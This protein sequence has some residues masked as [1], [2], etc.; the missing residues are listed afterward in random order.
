MTY[1]VQLVCNVPVI[2]SRWQR[3]ANCKKTI[4][5]A[6]T[7]FIVMFKITVTTPV[8][9]LL[10]VSGADTYGMVTINFYYYHNNYQWLIFNQLISTDSRQHDKTRRVHVVAISRNI[11]SITWTVDYCTLSRAIYKAIL[12]IFTKSVHFR[13]VLKVKN[14]FW[15]VVCGLNI[16]LQLLPT[17]YE[18]RRKVMFEK[19]YTVF[20]KFEN[21]I[22]NGYSKPI[23]KMSM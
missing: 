21:L 1:T 3:A 19:H 10:V 15:I 23:S 18:V 11:I 6:S 12:T 2:C 9:I 5:F 20:Q 16:T 17:A 13:K 7:S 14:I 22:V 8:S 4:D